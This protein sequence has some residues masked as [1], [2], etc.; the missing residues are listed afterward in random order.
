M[1]R[2]FFVDALFSCS[3]S[4]L[5]YQ[6]EAKYGGEAWYPARVI[7]LRREQLV[8]VKVGS[9]WIKQKKEVSSPTAKVT[10]YDVVYTD[11]SVEE[12]VSVDEVRPIIHRKDF[13]AHQ[14]CCC[15]QTALV[16]L[17]DCRW[18]CTV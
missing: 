5:C 13:I 12:K 17:R 16:A 1:R 8:D 6:V 2:H 9:R 10:G 14:V 11:G 7:G 4:L 15:R 3:A 18:H